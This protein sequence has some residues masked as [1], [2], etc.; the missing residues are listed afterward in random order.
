MP[1]AAS[2]LIYSQAQIIAKR[3]AQQRLVQALFHEEAKELP[4]VI[5]NHSESIYHQ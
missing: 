2:R 5:Y 4:P 1:V 3:Q